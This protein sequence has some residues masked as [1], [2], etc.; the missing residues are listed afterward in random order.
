MA[1]AKIGEEEKED[2]CKRVVACMLEA[3]KTAPAS[4]LAFHSARMLRN[5]SYSEGSPLRWQ[6]H[7]AGAIDAV[8]ALL[9]GV[10]ASREDGAAA[11]DPPT[12]DKKKPAA[13]AEPP[14]AAAAAA[15]PP[16]TDK[17][18]ASDEPPPAAAAAADAAPP[19]PPPAAEAPRP[20][21][22]DKDS[23][24]FQALQA[25]ALIYGAWAHDAKPSAGDK[26]G[27]DGSDGEVACARRA[28]EASVMCLAASPQVPLPCSLSIR[29]RLSLCALWR[30]FLCRRPSDPQVGRNGRPPREDARGDCQRRALQSGALP[31][32]L[33]LPCSRRSSCLPSSRAAG[34]HS[35]ARA[36]PPHAQFFGI[37]WSLGPWSGPLTCRVMATNGAF[38]LEL[39][40]KGAVELLAKVPAAPRLRPIF[41]SALLPSPGSN[42]PRRRRCC[43][44]AAP[45]GV[46]PGALRVG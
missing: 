4:F 5:L 43:F 19:A 16:P 20:P 7:N 36:P 12:S 41:A 44:A 23:I 13:D 11:A 9:T 32:A 28:S 26:G 3:A 38:A 17:K 22:P 1:V 24:R 46:V 27:V 25:L 30:S 39:A 18:P 2:G 34:L 8:E 35:C 6:L 10:K 21:T 37:D 14:A 15:D 40:Q 45:A 31:P 29:F 42:S 33:P